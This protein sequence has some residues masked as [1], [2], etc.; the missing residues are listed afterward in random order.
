[1]TKEHLI[2]VLTYTLEDARKDIKETIAMSGDKTSVHHLHGTIRKIEEMLQ[3]V[4]EEKTR[5][6]RQPNTSQE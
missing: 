4:Y 6:G 2:E 1:M 3:A 5:K